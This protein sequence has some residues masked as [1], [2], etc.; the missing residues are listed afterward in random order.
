MS[1][2]PLRLQLFVIAGSP[3]SRRAVANLRR[4]CDERIPGEYD[5]EVVDLVERP[6]EAATHDILAAP[7]L[8]KVAPAPVAR[9]IGDLSDPEPVIAALGLDGA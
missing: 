1:G 8:I 3:A 7:T 9:L 6:E 5:L 2:G 4:L